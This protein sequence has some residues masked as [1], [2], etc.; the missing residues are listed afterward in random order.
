MRAR[1]TTAL[2]LLGIAVGG[3]SRKPPSSAMQV[4]GTIDGFVYLT[5]P[6]GGV[7]V[8]AYP[9]DLETGMV[10]DQVLAQSAP[11][12]ADGA[13]HL[14]LGIYFGP[15][16]LSARGIGASY[17]EPSNGQTIT[18]DAAQALSTVWSTSDAAGDVQFQFARGAQLGGFIIGPFNDLAYAVAV[19][20]K[21]SFPTFQD[22]L[23]NAQLLFRDH[24][25]NDYWSTLPLDLT[26]G[27][28]R[29]WQ[30]PVAYDLELAGLSELAAR[31]AADSGSGGIASIHVLR[32]LERDAEDGL[33]DGR[34]KTGQ[35]SLGT[36][37]AE[38]NLDSETLR[39]TWS[40]SMALFLS[41]T[42]NKSTIAEGAVKDF[43]VRIAQ[44][45][46][47]LFPEQNPDGGGPPVYDVMPPT[48]TVVA[49]T[50][51]DESQLVATVSGGG[52][53]APTYSGATSTVTL[54][55]AST[56][57]FARFASH[58]GPNDAGIPVWRFLAAD[59]V[60]DEKK[61]A[62]QARVLRDDGTVLVDWYPLPSVTGS[63]Y[64]RQVVVSSALYGDLS[65]LSG[66]YRI[67][68]KATDE[69]GNASGV[70][71][72]KWS[73]TIRTPPL[74][75]RPGAAC[76]A[77]D[78]QCPYYYTLGGS[79]PNA[80]VAIS[81]AGLP[82]GN[83]KIAH[84]YVD[85]P[86][87]V[88]VRA[89]I[90]AAAGMTYSWGKKG[91]GYPYLS[92][93]SYTYGCAPSA[94]PDGSCYSIPMR[95]NE[96]TSVNQPGWGYHGLGFA[97]AGS[98]LGRCGDCEPTEAIIPANTTA[99]VWFYSGPYTFLWG[100]YAIGP[101][102]ASGNFPATAI[103]GPCE[104]FVAGCTASSSSCSVF[105]QAYYYLTRVQVV[106]S[107]TASLDSRVDP[108]APLQPALGTDVTNIAATAHA[109]TTNA[110]G[111]PSF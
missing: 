85:N 84:L 39:A 53:G 13:F 17:V 35:L 71:A 9:I 32:T 104:H 29:Q 11:T 28:M 81:G 78:G 88:P 79:S 16:Y 66:T 70:T 86:N 19:A 106:P 36:C 46:S 8:T 108:R 15:L 45:H 22:S 90:N 111:E 73:Q 67:E 80:Y 100:D 97:I 92:A 25:E 1:L 57:S 98:G 87:P 82:G 50:A 14:D 72:V 31:M 76:S 5:A 96:Y 94:L 61:I 105:G 6:V 38:C 95:G 62:V 56:P 65:V 30:P 60:S 18:W 42:A 3:C 37:K 101:N 103:G 2:L 27:D 21:P 102:S 99:D 93:F 89:R 26:T 33:F 24:V 64:N 107:V 41:S 51:V 44:R 110:P 7:V 34:S 52:T 4:A 48:I 91:F 75:E 54:D 74:R 47:D 69:K 68:L 49:N 10:S 63:G 12:T 59:N 77:V 40:D 20:K 55:G 83:L 43:L 58:Y 109:W 23:G